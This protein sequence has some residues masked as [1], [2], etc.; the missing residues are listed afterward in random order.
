MSVIR[1]FFCVSSFYEIGR[2]FLRWLLVAS[3]TMPAAE[4]STFNWQ[5]HEHC[6][7]V[8]ICV[9]SLPGDCTQKIGY[10]PMLNQVLFLRA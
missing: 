9:N 6:V 1:P 7:L 4:F 10:T 2:V 8:L 5:L 3:F